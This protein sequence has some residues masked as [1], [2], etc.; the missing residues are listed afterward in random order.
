MKIT[1][2]IYI[3]PMI[4]FVLTIA[5]VGFS[6]INDTIDNTISDMAKKG[7]ITLG[8]YIGKYIIES[9]YCIMIGFFIILMMLQTLD[10]KNY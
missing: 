9:L 1:I 8:I 2:N 6:L 10:I 3:I 5:L 7:N 4:I